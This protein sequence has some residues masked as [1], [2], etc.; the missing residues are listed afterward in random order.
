MEQVA[1]FL[2][3]NVELLRDL[4]QHKLA[5]HESTRKMLDMLSAQQD[6]SMIPRSL[7]PGWRM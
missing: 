1:F 5:G 3:L 7:P 2:Y 4:A 6:R